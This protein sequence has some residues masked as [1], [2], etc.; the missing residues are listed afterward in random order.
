MISRILVVDDESIVRDVLRNMLNVLRYEVV[1]VPDG[2]TAL[3]ILR[4]EAVPFDLA[5]VD[6]HMPGLSGLETIRRIREGH[7]DLLI[8]L[9]SG[10]EEAD[11]SEFQHERLIDGFVHKPFRM[12]DLK[13]SIEKVDSVRN[14]AMKEDLLMPTSGRRIRS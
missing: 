3:E 4:E 9:V 10:V 1:D 5:L 2:E 11:L 8:M 7:P 13:E 14:E 6:M 12:I